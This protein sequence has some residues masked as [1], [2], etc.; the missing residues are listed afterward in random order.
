MIK[1]YNTLSNEVEPLVLNEPNVV[2]MYVCGP[3]VYNYIHIGNARPVV[4]FDTVV[5]FLKSQGYHVNY[6]SNITDV[7]DK[8]INEADKA[9][10][11]EKEL[12]QQYIAEF[13]FDCES[14]HVDMG[15][16][17]LLATEHI[18]SIIHFIEKL[19]AIGFAYEV[20]G[21]V[22]FAINEAAQ[23][24]ELSKQKMEDLLSGARIEHNPDKHHDVDF[25]LWKP[26]T[27][28]I[29][30]DSPWGEGRP[31][32]HTECVAM[33]ADEF[34]GP[35]DIHG[36]GMD[37]KFPHHDNEI[38]QAKAI[39]W[40]KLATYWMHN[41]FVELDEQKMSKSEGNFFTAREVVETYG[42]KAV[43]YWLLSAHYRQPLTFSADI[44]LELQDLVGKMELSYQD[45]IVQL[46]LNNYATKSELT[47]EIVKE[48]YDKFIEVM[49]HDFNTANAITVVQESLK[50]LNIHMRQ[51]EKSFG[52]LV[53]YITLL[54]QFDDIL[55]IGFT[56]DVLVTET[57]QQL[58][59]EWKLAKQ[60]KD[61][62]K[63]DL[64]RDELLTKDIRVR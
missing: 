11:S 62:A 12:T 48:Q 63:A 10:I 46:K 64:I 53:Q 35:I 18:S 20:N 42:A 1:L 50:Q 21:T 59:M 16:K 29:K 9:G 26:T 61:F 43:R 28:G 24:A 15:V 38:V 41:G 13:L 25:V 45:A 54:R 39:G 5:R 30:W 19:I 57:D 4:F 60:N 58:Y 47:S 23:Y 2:N 36:G 14:L 7:D 6:A 52:V 17:R 56:T 27:M 34:G 22:Y 44:L 31:G 55:Q 51:G 49:S 40:N 33:I 37:L 32:W 3:T 8:I